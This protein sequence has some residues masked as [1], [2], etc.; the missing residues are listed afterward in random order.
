MEVTVQRLL[1]NQ[2]QPMQSLLEL[3]SIHLEESRA[4]LLHN[5][6]DCHARNQRTHVLRDH[7]KLQNIGISAMLWLGGYQASRCS[8]L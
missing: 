4:I 1:G 3:L 2:S 6:A 7:H 8:G 5:Y